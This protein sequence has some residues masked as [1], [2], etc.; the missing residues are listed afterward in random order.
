MGNGDNHGIVAVEILSVHFLAGILDHGAALV[1]KFLLDLNQFL[2]N[3]LAALGRIVKNG[4]QVLDG[5]AHLS[6]FIVQFFLLQTCELAQTHFNDGT[7]LNFGEAESFTQ[8]LYSVLGRIAALDDGNHLVNIVAGNYQSLQNMGTLLGFLEIKLG[9][10][11]HNLVTMLQEVVQ[12]LLEVKQ[13]GTS[14]NQ[15]HV[16]DAER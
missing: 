10:T 9:A 3:D 4:L 7:S 13:H 14:V 8:T 5:L 1:A 6:Q 2:L 12:Q 16:V 15:A 11:D